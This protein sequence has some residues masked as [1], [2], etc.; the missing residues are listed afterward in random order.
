MEK[1][2]GLNPGGDLVRKEWMDAPEDVHTIHAILVSNHDIKG[3]VARVL[4]ELKRI[5]DVDFATI[6]L[7]DE[8]G[9][10]F[11]HF[12]AEKDPVPG[13]AGSGE[14]HHFRGEIQGTSFEKVVKNGQPLILSSIGKEV[15]WFYP[16]RHKNG[17]RASLFFPLNH[18]G[19]V[20]GTLNFGSPLP[21]YFTEK[22]V[23]FLHRVAPGLT[24]SIEKALRDDEMKRKLN[25][26]TILYE[27]TGI[28]S[29]PMTLDQILS[30]T[31]RSL[32]S[33]FRSEIFGLLFLD[34]N[35]KKL[36]PHPSYIGMAAGEIEKLNL[37][38]GRGITGWV[39]QKG[40]PLLVRDVGRDERYLG[41]GGVLSEMCAPLK[42][43]DR[44]IGVIDAQSRGWNAFT[45]GDLRLLAVTGVHLATTI[46]NV[47]SD[48]RYRSVV[49]S[50]L[51]GVLVME[52]DFQLTYVNERLAKLL[53]RGREELM[54]KDF[55]D[56]LDGESRQRMAG[57]YG[58][59][60][61][62][63]GLPGHFEFRV[64]RKDET[65]R[66]VEMSSTVIYDSEGN[67]NTIA[68]LKDITEKRKMEE[69]LFQAE[70]LRAIGE[71][72]SGVAHDFNNAL[73]IILGNAQLL[74]LT[75]KDREARESLQVIEKVV[76][77]SAQTVRRLQ[78]FSRNRA[79]Q[80]LSKL[81]INAMIEDA[82]QITRPKW[83][84][85]VQSKGLDVEMVCNFEEIPSAAGNVSE[86]REVL[87]N[88]I[89]NSVEAMPE[90][91]KIEIRT[92]RK[93][94]KIYIRISDSGIGMNDG[95]RRKI[96]EP[97]FTTKPF[98]NTGL[99][100]S[101]SYGIIRRYGG[102]IEVES[103]EGKGTTFTIS[104]PV[105]AGGSE[106]GVAAACGKQRKE[107]R[108]LVIDD[109]E[110]VRGILAD[111][112]S[113]SRHQ[114]VVAANG[115]EGIRLFREEK[116]DMV[117]TDLGM[118]GMSG[119]EVCKEIRE[120]DPDIPV[121]MITGWGAE[122]S[123]K[124][125]EEHGVDF[126]LS[127][128]FDLEQILNVVVEAMSSKGGNCSPRTPFFLPLLGL[129]PR[130]RSQPS[131]GALSGSARS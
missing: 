126:V 99:G 109:E 80:E 58:R 56:Y 9:E 50:A 116:F 33:F 86:L 2:A 91:G 36:I 20:I 66:S 83:K 22:H 38:S 75:A 35:M 25:E 94:D 100:L 8:K 84:D 106:E 92:Y 12:P 125:R 53:G 46:E 52:G 54:G 24:V 32:N 128:P 70:K 21:G 28:S 10:G 76:K 23:R 127:K 122:V 5:L 90:G 74:L 78:E 41:P 40:V 48:E 18:E 79:P 19:R 129:L 27:M 89:F 105:E 101:M 115:E 72:A 26:L 57:Q 119:W 85:G 112:L 102:E 39:A 17:I 49:E 68:F 110:L 67:V 113:Q 108:I 81:D 31:V 59:G 95:V 4:D 97:F 123:R 88:M 45:E 51:D 30:E 73:A 71:M 107:G 121:G 131:P 114:V 120:I 93:K 63:T 3:A 42:V 77:D 69:Q 6:T 62:D 16:G 11:R 111:I 7:L 103:Q 60:R 55:R 14:G 15:R 118:P 64:V 47:R 117:L 65:I 37:S 124:K 96:F 13:G 61:K 1:V 82:V 130:D 29:S 43:G 104:L 34:E 98:T 44:V 87:T